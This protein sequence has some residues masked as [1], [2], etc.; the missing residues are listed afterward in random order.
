MACGTKAVVEKFWGRS[1]NQ[2]SNVAV[3]RKKFSR[4]HAPANSPQA[5]QIVL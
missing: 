4:G 3:Q 1:V 2:K 5:A